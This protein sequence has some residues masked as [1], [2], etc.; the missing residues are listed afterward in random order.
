MTTGNPQEIDPPAAA[1]GVGRRLGMAGLATLLT[2]V[3][4][5][6]VLAPP[7]RCPSVSEAELRAAS[8][9]TVDWF[10]RNQQADGTWLYLYDADSDTV[11]DEYNAV[12]H[13]GVTM[14]LYQ[15][16]AHGLPGALES[17]DRGVAWA[18]QRLVEH[19]DWAALRHDGRTT[20]GAAALLTAGL[21]ERRTV[22]GDHRYDDLLARLGRFLVA[23]TEPSGAVLASY[24]TRA[25]EPVAGV[26]SAYYTGEAYWAL[27][28]L[29]QLFPRDG[30]GEVADRIGAY[31]ATRR[32]DVEDHWP[33][34]PDHWAAYGL[35]ET[36]EFAERDGTEPLTADELGYARSQ[37]G[38]W[39]AQ[40]RWVS[41]RFGPWGAVVRT[42]QAPRGGGYGVIGEGLTGLWRA[43]GDEPRLAD[44][45]APL[46]ERATC[47][48]G[49]A[50]DR[51]VDAAEAADYPSPDRAR[52]AWFLE[53]E[54]RMDDQQHA[55]AALLRT[56]AIVDEA[57]DQPTGAS[58]DE[59]SEPARPAP[60]AWVWAAALLAALN[61]CRAGL[62][63][64]RGTRDRRTV[65]GVA[66]LGAAGGI[67]VVIA[68]ALVA[69]PALDAAGVS[70]PALRIAAGAV[71]VVV[72]GADLV[73]RPPSAEPS[74]PG[75]RAALVPVA[76][77]LTA[78]PV[79]ILLAVSARADR[80][81][82]LVAA[83][84]ALGVAVLTAVA[85]YTPVR[86]PGR[87]VVSWGGRLTAA[88]LVATSVLLI[89]D[90]VYDT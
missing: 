84:L 54:T 87:R 90:G 31:L 18:E 35:A 61:P 29:H 81:L 67:L 21:A 44:L 4:A 57:S 3:V 73:R 32:D 7:E 56:I 9:E 14:G 8:G 65:A 48:A 66:A 22:T 40:V 50:V 11:P 70:N 12:R 23:Q 51:Q 85:T 15:A 42:P 60:S 38:L 41:Q 19:D 36:V 59:R 34:I 52:G 5:F 83:T 77:P 1:R 20:A 6:G 53:G 74:L 86:G 46:A 10:V 82:A 39:G 49:L 55:L 16:A 27:A 76:V 28:R 79:L 24:D 69:V 64:P 80:G 33:A 13:A 78:R 75:W 43:A 89:V 62:G 63:V 88:V 37:A 58:T 25:G 26:Y 17:A 72:G 68:V 2:G 47:I 30:W 71:A 45:R